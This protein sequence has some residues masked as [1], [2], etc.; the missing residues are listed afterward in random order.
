MG[1]MR[2]QVVSIV[3]HELTG[4]FSNPDIEFL[5]KCESI[6]W[7]SLLIAYTSL[8]NRFNSCCLS[9]EEAFKGVLPLTQVKVIRKV[10]NPGE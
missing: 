5:D 3:T 9:N 4:F 2:Q 6:R 1:D 7:N 10:S 8:C